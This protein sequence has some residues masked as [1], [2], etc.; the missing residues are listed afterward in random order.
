MNALVKSHLHYLAVVL[1]GVI[2]NFSIPLEKHQSWANKIVL[3][4]IH[5]L[6]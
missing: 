3:S 1:G 4:L 5:R 6:N 2:V